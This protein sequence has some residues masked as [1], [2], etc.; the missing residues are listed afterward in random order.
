MLGETLSRNVERM[1]RQ[2]PQLNRTEAV[3]AGV[4]ESFTAIIDDI[5]VA[6]G[7]SQ[8]S[9]AQDTTLSAARGAV[10]A[11]QIGQGFYRHLV[12][13]LNSL[14]ILVVVFEAVHTG[15]W[16]RLTKFNYLDIKSLVTASSAG[17]VG[18]VKAVLDAHC[19]EGTQWVADPSDPV[20]GAVKIEWS[21]NCTLGDTKTMAIVKSSDYELMRSRKARK[22]RSTESIKSVGLEPISR[23]LLDSH[24]D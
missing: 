16:N 15:C 18:I 13:A 23:P 20:V 1:Q 6:Y 7:A 24:L 10:E 19:E 17:G 14:M 3:L 5:L 8:T 21:S 4:E 22:A 9:N 2:K 11:L 12:F